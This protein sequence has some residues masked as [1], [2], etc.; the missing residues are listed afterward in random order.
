[1]AIAFRAA[2]TGSMDSGEADDQPLTVT[3][4][5]EVQAGDLMLMV[6]AHANSTGEVLETPDGWSQVYVEDE[7]GYHS[8]LYRRVAQSTDAGTVATAIS[9]CKAKAACVVGVW[10]GVD[11][12]D[13]IAQKAEALDTASG[14]SHVTPT[15]TTT[16]DASRIVIGLAKKAT[17]LTMITTPQGYTERAELVQDAGGGANAWLADKSVTS[18]GTYGGE[19]VVTDVASSNTSLWTIALR[20]AVTTQ[21]ARPAADVAHANATGVPDASAHYADLAA[22]DDNHY[23]EM[24]SGGYTEV[25]F[26]ALVDPDDDTGHTISYRA[27]YTSGASAATVQAEVRQGSTVIA[28][29][30]DNVSGDWAGYTHTLAEAEAAL[31]TDYADLRVRFTAAS[32]AS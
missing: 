19:S 10:S 14:T 12:S 6:I 11:R 23:V 17:H 8:G 3:L 18:A 2:A 29:F 7:G 22:S 5:S 26:S 21:T 1:M 15:V 16:I 28:T 25:K 27:C 20:P 30:S 9:A 24:V 13:P 31:I 32:I 4:P